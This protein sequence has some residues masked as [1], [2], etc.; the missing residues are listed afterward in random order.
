[1]LNKGDFDERI[2]VSETASQEIGANPASGVS[3]TI[4]PEELRVRM[5]AKASLRQHME[6]VK[7]TPQTPL[8]NRHYLKSKSS[9]NERTPVSSATQTVSQLHTLLIGHSG[10]PSRDLLDIFQECGSRDPTDIILRRVGEMSHT[11]ISAYTRPLQLDPGDEDWSMCTKTIHVHEESASHSNSSSLP[12][13]SSSLPSNSS[14]SVDPVSVNPLLAS[15][16]EFA[17]KRL[18]LVVALYYKVLENIMRRERKRVKESGSGQLSEKMGTLLSNEVFHLSLFTC[19]IEIVVF[20]YNSKRTFPWIIH[21]YEDFK[22]LRFQPYHFY[23][24]IELVIRD[25]DSLSRS[26]VK[27]LNMIEERILEQLAWKRDSALWDSIRVPGSPTGSAGSGVPSCQDVALPSS[28]GGPGDSILA[29]PLSTVKRLQQ[30]S[31]PIPSMAADR[32]SSPVTSAKRR[33]FDSTASAG[34]NDTQVVQLQIPSKE[35][36]SFHWFFTLV[37]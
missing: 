5:S 35:R 11:F 36:V 6:E 12:S 29:S 27:H 30:F 20:S 3:P 8:T 28:A 4:T 18:E 25:E 2:F 14:V 10:E 34:T 22:D 16:N 7:M 17:K 19:C 26:V 13:N 23:K 37:V 31:S 1:M 15:S 24:V 21:V 32:F 9:E 33:L